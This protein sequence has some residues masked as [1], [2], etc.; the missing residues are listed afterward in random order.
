MVIDLPDAV[1]L[2]G[3]LVMVIALLVTA[4]RL[5]RLTRRVAE[6]G[7][8]IRD[9]ERTLQALCAGAR[10]L[11]DSLRAME[12]R[13]RGAQHRLDDLDGV[14]PQGRLYR[15]AIERAR[16]GADQKELVDTFGLEPG[17][18]ELLRRL[19]TPA[20]RHLN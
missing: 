12:Q 18:A 7:R 17:E 13:M 6:Q 10:G 2:T 16:N 8:H 5:R 4:H 20:G 3:L 14:E 9:Q 1:A 11:G 19:H 15:Q